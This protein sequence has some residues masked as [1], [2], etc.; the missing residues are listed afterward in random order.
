M[1]CEMGGSLNNYKSFLLVEILNLEITELCRVV[2]IKW[3]SG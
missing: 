1:E 3:Q 2:F